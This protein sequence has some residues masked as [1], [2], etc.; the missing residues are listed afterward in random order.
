MVLTEPHTVPY[1]DL[2]L[3][4]H[5][6]P[7]LYWL[8]DIQ[9]Y[10]HLLESHIQ[11]LMWHLYN[12]N[13]YIKVSQPFLQLQHPLKVCTILRHPSLKMKILLG[14]RSSPSHQSP[15]PPTL[16]VS[17]TS[18]FLYQRVPP[19]HSPPHSHPPQSLQNSTFSFIHLQTHRSIVQSHGVVSPPTG[20]GH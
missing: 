12:H 1:T 13:F 2:A 4:F 3:I 7:Y 5:I 9:T 10:T 6:Q 11:L 19:S 15:P 20:V 8:Y 17:I 14:I 16:G 18:E